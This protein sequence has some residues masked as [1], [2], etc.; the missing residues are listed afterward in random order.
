ME[1]ILRDD[2]TH[3]LKRTNGCELEDSM[4][5]TMAGSGEQYE[6]SARVGLSDRCLELGLHQKWFP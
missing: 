1:Y 5:D 4:K 3:A 6:E 2:I